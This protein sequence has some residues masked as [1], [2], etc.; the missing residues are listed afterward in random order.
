MS[1]FVFVYGTLLSEERN[2]H[3]LE[4]SELLGKEV[5][6]GF[7]MKD[8]GFFPACMED[9]NSEVAIL[10]EV[11]EIST[12]TLAILDGLEGY[13]DFYNRVLVR[14]FIGEAWI[15]INNNVG[16]CPTIESG[17]WKSYTKERKI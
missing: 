17:D 12:K 16:H 6:Y 13:P 8:L 4:Y 2:N 10:G 7:K 14:T 15:Y 1:N 5:V 3:Y 9:S 11:W